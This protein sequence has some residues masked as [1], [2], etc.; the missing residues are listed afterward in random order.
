MADEYVSNIRIRIICDCRD[1]TSGA[2]VKGTLHQGTDP[3]A[4]VTVP[5]NRV[6]A[7]KLDS[8]GLPIPGAFLVLSQGQLDAD[9]TVVP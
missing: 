8:Q 6:G 4:G 7:I 3:T 5:T 9:Y 1:A 2:G